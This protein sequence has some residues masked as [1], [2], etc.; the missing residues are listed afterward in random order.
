M[1]NGRKITITTGSKNRLDHLRQALST[2][3]TL[4]EV[5]SIIIVDW[6]STIPLHDALADFQ[7]PRLHIVRALN[8]P[9]WC[10]A[11]CHNLELQ[12]VGNTGLLLR[13]DNDTLVHKNFFTH[14][15]FLEN[16]FYA[17]S[18]PHVLGDKKNLAGTLFIEAAHLSKING[19]NERLIHYGCEDDDLYTRLNMA[20]FTW[21]MCNIDVLE[22]IPHDDIS[23][24]EHLQITND[25]SISKSH[26]NR[27]Q[28]TALSQNLA[29]NQPWTC[30][31]RRTLWRVSTICKRY[32]TATA[33]I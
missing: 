18:W 20:G 19:Y 29:L 9:F 33:I 28:L 25:P 32:S 3:L 7:D 24:L 5:D 22:H 31:D 30:T 4:T 26:I 6:E 1:I 12:L 23:R 21:R 2:W 17:V 13:L 8:Q 10:N 27:A 14:H 16:S 15:P 11:K